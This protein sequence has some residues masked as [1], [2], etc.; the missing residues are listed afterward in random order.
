MAVL[1]LDIFPSL[2]LVVP[3]PAPA[4]GEAF[5]SST[6]PHLLRVWLCSKLLPFGEGSSFFL[7]LKKNEELWYCK[8]LVRSIPSLS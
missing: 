7:A 1:I 2:Y 5:V 4:F 6:G 3:V 8:N